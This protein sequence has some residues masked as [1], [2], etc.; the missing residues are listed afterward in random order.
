LAVSTTDESLIVRVSRAAVEQL[1]P[2]EIESFRATSRAFLADPHRF[3]RRGESKGA[4]LG[5]GVE[6]ICDPL[7]P[8]VLS[9]VTGVVT[10]LVT[11]PARHGL[12]AV[13]R[14]CRRPFARSLPDR[15]GSLTTGPQIDSARIRQLVQ[16]AADRR[17]SRNDQQL[18][19]DL[20]TRELC[21]VFGCA[22]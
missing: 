16:F 17:G 13:W 14:W 7:T 22:S 8:F 12:A 2:G 9:V 21:S 11:P 15:H 6:Q 4:P 10:E 3:A 1:A 20:V 19:V 5:L 18:V